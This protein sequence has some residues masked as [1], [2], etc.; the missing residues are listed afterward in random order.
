MNVTD[1]QNLVSGITDRDYQQLQTSVYASIQ[2]AALRGSWSLIITEKI[3]PKRNR[4]IDELRAN[5]FTVN[6]NLIDP[7]Q[8]RVRWNLP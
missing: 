2:N 6:T 4:L 5:G 1:A 3:T 7:N 8:I